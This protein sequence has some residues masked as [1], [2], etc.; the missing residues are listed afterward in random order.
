MKT[1]RF[2]DGASGE[3]KGLV[4]GSAHVT[5]SLL[6]RRYDGFPT[7]HQL[8]REIGRHKET[9]DPQSRGR[10][11]SASW[12]HPTSPRRYK[13]RPQS[14]MSRGSATGPASSLTGA[15]R[16]RLLRG[17][18]RFGARLGGL[19]HQR[20]R[21]RFA[22]T[23]V[24]CLGSAGNLSSSSPYTI[25]MSSASV[26]VHHCNCQFVQAVQFQ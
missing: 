4:H 17:T 5:V 13:Q 7:R 25:T 22:A 14:G 18:P 10:A 23:A 20:V 24:L 12:Y 6:R 15:T 9:A 11:V 16:R 3:R 21:S 1:V 26:R 19:I 2:H 8:T